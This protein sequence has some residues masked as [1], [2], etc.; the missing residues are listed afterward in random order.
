MNP[1]N[2]FEQ[3]CFSE[4]Q[5]QCDHGCWDA[6]RDIFFKIPMKVLGWRMQEGF[7][8]SNCGLYADSAAEF[9]V[10]RTRKNAQEVFDKLSQRPGQLGEDTLRAGT[11]VPDAWLYS[12]K[13]LINVDERGQ[14]NWFVG[15]QVPCP[16]ED[17]LPVPSLPPCMMP[18]KTL[19][20]TVMETAS[21]D[22]SMQ[23]V[24][25]I[26]TVAAVALTAFCLWRRFR[27]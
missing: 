7:Q 16:I 27:K 18:E 14:A 5:K 17:N 6:N 15:E 24:A 3:V 9:V 4:T 20:S 22:S 13:Y 12:R 8:L 26:A 21:S 11:I 10:V 19:P 1:V 2:K 23:T 25:V